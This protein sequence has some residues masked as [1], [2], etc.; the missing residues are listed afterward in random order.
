[1][2]N[3]AYMMY[4]TEKKGVFIIVLATEYESYL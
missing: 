3:V 1:M 2:L 4:F